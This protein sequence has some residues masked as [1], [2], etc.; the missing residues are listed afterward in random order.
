VHGKVPGL[1][2]AGYESAAQAAE[3]GCPVANA[4]RNNVAITINATL[5]Q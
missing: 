2:P 1:E 4:L 5:D 3:Q